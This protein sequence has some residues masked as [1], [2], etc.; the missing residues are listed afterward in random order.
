VRL[1]SI[2]AKNLNLSDKQKI[3][4]KQGNSSVVAVVE[5]DD[6]ISENCLWVPL[7]SATASKLRGN[8]QEISVETI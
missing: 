8:N 4:L 1:S 5:V 3:N 7:S 6:S 2:S